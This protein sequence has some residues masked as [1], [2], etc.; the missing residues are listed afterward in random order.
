MLVASE[1]EARQVLKCP[2]CQVSEVRVRSAP[3]T[4]SA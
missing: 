4:K 2:T 3:Y 1:T